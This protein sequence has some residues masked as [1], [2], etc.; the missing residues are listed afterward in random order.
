MERC[1]LS[2]ISLNKIYKVISL[3]IDSV[4][5]KAL[6]NI[7]VAIGRKV[8]LIGKVLTD[9]MTIKI[10]DCRISLRKNL[11]DKINVEFVKNI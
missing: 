6:D 11:A 2:E 10:E 1:N 5:S 7:G 9:P 8:S 4:S 3:D